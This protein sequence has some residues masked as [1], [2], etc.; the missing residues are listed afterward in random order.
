MKSKVETGHARNV[1]NFKKLIQT[2][3][4]FSLYN[5][6]M[7][8]ISLESL[9]EMY[10]SAHYVV[11]DVER[12]RKENSIAIHKRQQEYKRLKPLATRLYNMAAILNLNEGDMEQ[13]KS[14]RNVIQGSPQ[15]K[16]KI[17]A[18][19]RQSVRAYST[20]RQSFTQLA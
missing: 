16:R 14:L 1:E 11:M 10:K 19:E 4:P 7:K 3:K 13:I 6:S 5:P 18:M 17:S 9:E 20:S 15:T 2:V 8:E 12:K